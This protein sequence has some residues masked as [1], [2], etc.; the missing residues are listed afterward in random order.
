MKK[1]VSILSLAVVFAA[2]GNGE[3]K[4]PE[5]DSLKIQD[6]IKTAD[7]LAKAAAASD[8]TKK[9]SDSTAPKADSAA[10]K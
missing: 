10:K 9:A 5:V 6:S 2:C 1:L 8:T 3:T 7:S 4:A